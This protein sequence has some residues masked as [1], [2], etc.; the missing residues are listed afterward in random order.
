MLQLTYKSLDY[1]FKRPIK[2]PDGIKTKQSALLLS[3]SFAKMRGF[4]ETTESAYYQNTVQKMTELLEKQEKVLNSY[5]LNTPQRFWHFLHH[6]LPDSNF[7]IAA[8]D[9]AGWDLW[10]KI[11]FTS[12]QDLMELSNVQNPL[13][14]YTIDLCSAEEIPTRIGLK[15]WPIYK[16]Q[17][18]GKQDKER[19]EA[20]REAA[21]DAIIRVD[22]NESWTEE[23]A[24]SLL[25]TLEDCRVEYIEQPFS[26][27]A[28]EV[29]KKFRQS[30][31]I[32]II[33]DEACQD[34]RDL[35]RCLGQY[36]GINIK[37]SKCGGL[38]PALRMIKSIR[39]SGKKVVLGS[40]VEGNIGATAAAQ[41]LPLADYA[42]IDGPLLIEKSP[43]EGLV[44]KDGVITLPS[45]PGLG[46][47]YP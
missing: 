17:L 45:G 16:L 10:A 43:G 27:A 46:L 15:P 9:I 22:A 8:L 47:E 42:D 19:L 31:T 14:S 11:N 7:L 44:I 38:T 23:G 33:G 37:L 28:T 6:L 25:K 32:P 36:D 13:T 20:L 39:D 41:L 34:E 21:P 2:T 24:E 40:M 35:Q 30:T 29:L 4:G 5:A 12:V 1:T 26:R 18:D 3:L